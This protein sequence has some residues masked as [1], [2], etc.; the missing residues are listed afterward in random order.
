MELSWIKAH[1]G[2]RGNERAD[3][4]AKEAVSGKT[5][6]ECH[7][8]IPKS[9]VWNEL[10]EQSAKQWQNERER[11]S[12][13]VITKSFFQKI[14]DRL[15]IRINETPNFTVM[16]TGDGIYIIVQV[17]NIREPDVLMR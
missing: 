12:K 14:L 9:A 1:A 15:K 8:R 2:Q 11:S 13:G 10:N 4:L 17:Q 16:V 7:T 5:I 6:E 3:H